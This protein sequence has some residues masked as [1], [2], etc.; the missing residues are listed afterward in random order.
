MTHEEM[1]RT[2]EF[3]L[4]Q[5]ANFA[6]NIEKLTGVMQQF[7]A[8][9]NRLEGAFVG[10]FNIVTETAKSQQ[11]LTEQLIGLSTQVTELKEAQAHTDD[12]LNALINL[13]ERYISERGNG[14]T[15][16]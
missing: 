16:A 3:V 1:E 5:Q 8:R 11:I 2:M 15:R 10:V 13:V 12:R 4:K 14:E 9:M 6:V 7:D